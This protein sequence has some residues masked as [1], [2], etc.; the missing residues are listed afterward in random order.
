MKHRYAG[1][2]FT[3]LGPAPSAYPSLV[4]TL[5]ASYLYLLSQLLLTSEFSQHCPAN[6]E[7][8]SAEGSHGNTEGYSF[9]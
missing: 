6:Q 1:H 5:S 4:S 9:P 3:L 7:D 8:G 2:S